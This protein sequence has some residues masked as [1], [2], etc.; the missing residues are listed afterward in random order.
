MRRTAPLSGILRWVFVASFLVGVAACQRRDAPALSPTAQARPEGIAWF[1]GDPAAAFAAAAAQHKPVLLYWGAVWCPP[2]HDLKAHVFSRQDFRDA[3]RQFIPV[4]LDG[5]SPGAQRAG[6]EFHVLGYPTLVVLSADRSEILRISGGQDLAGYAEALDVALENLRPLSELVASLR[7]DAGRSLTGP[8]CRRLAY[9]GWDADPRVRTQDLLES[10]ELARQRCPPTSTLERDRL[11]VLAADRGARAERAALDAGRPA[12][13]RLTQQLRDVEAL[14]ANPDRALA[15]GAALVALGEDFFVV[16][17]KL[18]ARGLDALRTRWHALMDAI[19]TDAR[20]DDATRLLGAA[21][22]VQAAKALDADGKL[23]PDVAARARATLDRFLARDYPADARAGIV[24]SASWALLLLGDD[25][26][27]RRLLEEQI[28]T[29]KTPYYYLPDL[30][31]LEERAGNEAAALTL[32]ERGYREAQGPATRFQW[33]AL[34]VAGLLRIS[35]DDEPRIREATLALIEE[36]A[37][38]DRIHARARSRLG[39]LHDSLQQWAGKTKNAPTL[40][41]IGERWTKICAALPPTDE[42]RRE[43]PALLFGS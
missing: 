17:R 39:R 3:L 19:E 5:D 14:L 29:S 26:R 34:Y 41:A 9:N 40:A 37:G 13:G 32:L 27:L 24:N 6:E 28:R 22:R 1:E 30:A 15:A 31:D 10:L 18:N 42:V 2:C 12:S 25:E 8:E 16:E 23:P 33:G 43:C 7:S 35:P 20:F 36:L 4:Y 21:A 11:T 38:P